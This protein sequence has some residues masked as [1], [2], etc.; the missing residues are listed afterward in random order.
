MAEWRQRSGVRPAELL[1][2]SQVRFKAD[3]SQRD[4]DT[5]LFQSLQFIEQIRPAVDELRWQRFVAGRSAVNC[6]GDVGIKELEPIP[7]SNGNGLVREAELVERAVKPIAG[8]VARENSSSS[9]TTVSGWGQANNQ[10]PRSGITEAGDRPP[11]IF[12]IAEPAN[13]VARDL[14]AIFD[15]SRAAPAIDDFTLGRPLAHSE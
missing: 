7:A 14:F 12:P 8:A 10:K 4:D 13:F 5:H 11:P 6:R 1:A 15:Q 3:Q 2:G 9:I